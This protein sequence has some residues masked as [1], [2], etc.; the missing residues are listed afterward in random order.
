MFFYLY[1]IDII[2]YKLFLFG[3]E[4]LAP[5]DSLI[6]NIHLSKSRIRVLSIS[7]CVVPVLF[8]CK[9]TVKNQEEIDEAME[10][11]KKTLA[12]F[13]LKNISLEVERLK[14][15]FYDDLNDDLVV[16]KCKL[17]KN[18]D[19]AKFSSSYVSKVVKEFNCFKE[20]LIISKNIKG[21]CLLKINIKEDHVVYNQ[22]KQVMVDTI[23]D[24]AVF[25]NTE[26]PKL[27]CCAISLKY[28]N[29][30]IEGYSLCINGIKM[31]SGV[32]DK[33]GELKTIKSGNDTFITYS[34]T[35]N[36]ISDI[37]SRL[38]KEQV[39]NVVVYNLS[40]GILNQFD[41]RRF[42]LCDFYTFSSG[43][44][45][46]RDFSLVDLSE[47]FNYK[48]PSFNFTFHRGETFSELCCDSKTIYELY[49]LSDALLLAKE[50]AEISGYIINKALSNN[51]A[52]IIDYSLLH[53]LYDR[54]YLFPPAKK[55]IPKHYTGG[56]VLNPLVG[57]YDTAILLLDFN[58]LYPSI[59]QEFNVCFSTIGK[60]NIDC[61]NIKTEDE[62]ENFK[63]LEKLSLNSKKGFLPQIISNLVARRKEI[64]KVI[65][66]NTTGNIKIYDIRQKALKLLA[67]SIYGCLGF[68]V[69]RFCNYTMASY[70]TK[71]GR[72][73]L[74]ETRDI[75]T[76]ELGYKV[77]Y[78]DTDSIMINTQLK[79]CNE[80]LN[81]INDIAEEIKNKINL[82]YKNIEI[83]L[84]KIFIRLFL[85]TK[86]RYAAVFFD[87]KNGYRN[88]YKGIDSVRRDI[89]NAAVE[90]LD[91]VLKIL[92][93]HK[94][95]IDNTETRDEIYSVLHREAAN[96]RQRKAEDF[97]INT[98]LSKPLDKYDIKAP[99]PHVH[100]ANRLKEKGILFNQGDMISFV[101][102]QTGN[103]EPV[104]KRAF[105]LSEAEKIDYDY[106]ISNQILPS[107]SRTLQITN[108]VSNENIQRIFGCKSAKTSSQEISTHS[109]QFIT[110]CCNKIQGPKECCSGC[111]EKISEN[112]YFFKVKEMIKKEITSLYNIKPECIDCNQRFDRLEV[113][114]QFCGS[115]LTFKPQNEEFDIFL[116]NLDQSFRGTEFNRVKRFIKMHIDHSRFKTF[117]LRLYFN[118]E[119]ENFIRNK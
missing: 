76:E 26:L 53:E 4:I 39:D 89:C 99:L 50:L 94:K 29:N 86:K 30:V 48:I 65:K 67:N 90:I 60:Q 44:I 12:S 38:D 64:K 87:G 74:V 27:N 92:L 61:F 100:L 28:N 91:T 68:P 117:D 46:S 113:V 73:L 109:I 98:A 93:D 115:I 10:D 70:I 118:E 13:K 110:D 66:Q 42:L 40:N 15:I 32:V 107:L 97:V 5:E 108:F 21:P 96:L 106:Y 31:V 3:R 112:F 59:I 58:S 82:K 23:D 79:Y 62:I 72:D 16:I 33:S 1:N 20:Y 36:M 2:N 22:Y 95:N 54:K 37:H 47:Y 63:E 41:F 75:A 34:N 11:I 52:E 6:E 35:K 81:Q 17:K 8:I 80:N 119:I 56:K 83:D 101:V 116:D 25:G 85:Y 88:E 102:C 9:N 19:L 45:K 49:I 7:K 69:S 104:H 43:S 51:R 55:S 77:I 84:E 103:N 111:K 57:Y 105:L 18:I 114:C 71:K 14:N 24:I 78:G